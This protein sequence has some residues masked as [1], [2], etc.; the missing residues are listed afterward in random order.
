VLDRYGI[1][2]LFALVAALFPP[3]GLFMSWLVRPKKPN[4]AKLST[5]ECGLEFEDFPEA[6]Q[7]IWVQF[8]VQYYIYALIFV[9]F[10]VEVVFLYPWAVAYNALGLFALVEMVLFLAI[11]VVAL[12][13]AWR[14]GQ[15]EW[16]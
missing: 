1:V 13:Y 10:D 6:A 5:Y 16:L 12:V 11:L 14:K 2:A 9:V 4:R 7:Q 15:L 8:R 3:I